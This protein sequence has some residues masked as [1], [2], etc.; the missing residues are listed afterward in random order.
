M[1]A[2]ERVRSG[3]SWEDFC[4]TLKSAG[5]AIL[6]SDAPDTLLDRAEGWRYLSRLTR[7]G[8]EMMVE[9]ADP[10]FPRF[11]YSNSTTL[12]MGGDNPDNQVCNATVSG[13]RRYRIWG[14]RGTAPYF[15]VGSVANRMATEGTMVPTGDLYE[16][17]I[18]FGPDGS[19]EIIASQDPQARNWLPMAPDSTAII[20]RATFFDRTREEPATLNIECLDR[21]ARPATLSPEQIDQSLMRAAAFVRGTANVFGNWAQGFSAQPNCLPALDQAPFRRAGAHASIHYFHGYWQLQPDEALVISLKEPECAY[22][23]LVLQNHW[24]ESLD[25]RYLPVHVNKGS[26]TR[27]ADGTVTI[28]IAAS[29]PGFSN[30]LDTDGHT[31]GTMLLRWVGAREY[32]VPDC[33]VVK[34]QTLTPAG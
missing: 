26:V 12:K 33:K 20:C 5:S 30:F 24:M 10:D 18:D 34:L 21:P 25:Y 16:E 29:N 4:D 8:L 14:K 27:A 17:N 13:N 1:T 19:F 2:E 9:H 3:R 15:S 32:P 11:Y 31:C 7:L 22:W 6:R 23:S 28:L